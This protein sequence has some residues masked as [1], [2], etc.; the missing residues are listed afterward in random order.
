MYAAPNKPVQYGLP[1]ARIVFS[2]VNS[3]F[4]TARADFGKVAP[5]VIN[6]FKMIQGAKFDWQTCKWVFPLNAHD[7]LQVRT[8]FLVIE[9][10]I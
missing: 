8:P 2:I 5:E 7:I 3:K 10:C 9:S 4:F 1:N 6:T